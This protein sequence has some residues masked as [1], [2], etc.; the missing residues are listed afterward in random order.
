MFRKERNVNNPPRTWYAAARRGSETAVPVR[1]LSQS[2]FVTT[3]A[4]SSR[5]GGTSVT[6]SRGGL[7]HRVTLPLTLFEYGFARGAPAPLTVRERFTSQAEVDFLNS[8]AGCQLRSLEREYGRVMRQYI[9]RS[10]PL[11]GARVLVLGCGAPASLIPVLE[12]G[13]AEAVFVDV[14]RPALDKLSSAVEARG[15]RATLVA[16]YVQQ[17]AWEYLG[18]NEGAA[19]DFVLAT[20]CVGLILAHAPGRTVPALL[21]LVVDVLK[22]GGSFVTDHHE[23]FSSPRCVG[24]PVAEGLSDVDY[25]LATVAGRYAADI[26]Y[27]WNI[28]HPDA[29]IVTRFCPRRT[30][31]SRIQEWHLFHFRVP[32]ADGPRPGAPLSARRP[33]APTPFPLPPLQPFDSV[34]DAMVPVNH[35]GT[36]RVVSDA[37]LHS[38]DV[39]RV[40]P[41]VDGVPGV[42]VIKGRAAAFMS[43]TRSTAVA[44]SCDVSPALVLTAELVATRELDAVLVC[45]G[46]LVVGSTRCDPNDDVA[47]R[48]VSRV[49]DKLGASGIIASSP[50]LMKSLVG[51]AVA[52]VAPTGRAVTIPV[53]GVTPIVDGRYG[54]FLKVS[55]AHT[56]DAKPSEVRRLLDFGYDAIDLPPPDIGDPPLDSDAVFEYSLVGPGQRWVPVRRRDDKTWSDTPGAVVHTVCAALAS[57][58]RGVTGT[59]HD[60]VSRMC[61]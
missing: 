58:D 31:P 16:D 1:A 60:L 40:R 24:R 49:I 47:F 9:T 43:S 54:T 38:F 5:S 35:K 22:P 8:E 21:D 27:S 18:E 20:K 48:S 52:L 7:T 15:A 4:K 13:V 42:L 51:D 41:K 56:V 32:H 30:G 44:L 57:F 29:A 34:R 26:G 28:G 33:P 14:S 59:V 45:T 25:T 36:K 11:A 37:D 10:I 2:S 12:R 55:A 23:A 50:D 39:G 6:G 19:F 61:R 53:D 3:V 46:L 17:D